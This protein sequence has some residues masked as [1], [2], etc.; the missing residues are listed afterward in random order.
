MLASKIVE[1]EKENFMSDSSNVLK[2]ILFLMILYLLKVADFIFLPFVI[3]LFFFSLIYILSSKYKQFLLDRLHLPIWTAAF[4]KALSIITIAGVVYFIVVGIESNINNVYYRFADYQNNINQLMEK[5]RILLG[6]NHKITISSLLKDI[7]IT[8]SIGNLAHGFASFVSMSIMVLVYVLFL[9]LEEKSLI[10]KFPSIF[11]NSKKHSE[12]VKMIKKIYSKIEIYMS[13]KLFTSFLTGVLGYIL[14]KSLN[15]DFALFWA[16]LMFLFNFIPT[17][18]SIISSVFPILFAALQFNGEF[19]P[20]SIIAIGIIFIQ[21]LIGNI[22]DPKIMGKRLNL[23]PLLLILSLVIWGG[24]WGIAG[25][26]LCVPIMIIITII[27]LQ[28]PSTKKFA[29]LLTS[30]GETF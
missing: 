21:L 5:I 14:M 22:I 27:L 29:L 7:N 4:A 24:I 30:D 20:V 23:S 17:I 25:M 11:D 12:A 8:K 16:I 26:F 3:A 1:I 2:F 6:L 19:F 13:V 9:L 18:G 28:I 15:L 10:K